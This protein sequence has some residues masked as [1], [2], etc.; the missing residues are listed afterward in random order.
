MNKA[1]RP[2]DNTDPD[3]SESDRVLGPKAWT[4]LIAIGLVLCVAILVVISVLTARPSVDPTVHAD[5]LAL[6]NSQQPDPSAPSRYPELIEALI[7]FDRLTVQIVQD[8]PSAEDD[9][10][11]RDGIVW[12]AILEEPDPEE[13]DL[14]LLAEKAEGV[15]QAFDILEEQG[16]FDRITEL[17]QSPNLATNYPTSLD[18]AG[19]VKPMIEWELPYLSSW[20]LYVDAIAARSRI[21]AEIGDPEAAA[22][23]LEL[24]SRLPGVLTR[25]ATFVERTVGLS[26]LAPI[27]REIEFICTRTEITPQVLTTL[28]AIHQQISDLGDPIVAIQGEKLF[29]RDMLYRTHTAG[30]RYI[31][32]S[33]EYFTSGTWPPEPIELTDR[34]KDVTGYVAASRDASLV[35]SEEIFRHYE[36]AMLEQDPVQRDRRIEDAHDAENS[37]SD[38]YAFLKAAGPSLEF[39][40]T[41]DFHHRA[42][43]TALGILLAMAE[44]RLDHGDWPTSLDQL[45][46]DYLDAIP[47]DP[48]TGDPF[49]YDHTPGESPSLERLGL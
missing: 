1:D 29:L 11:S 24:A 40:I 18:A 3:R 38:R 16:A 43:L 8:L 31:P 14:E 20:R 37:L 7:E 2:A 32:S 9:H 44:H 23:H 15:R 42:H 30:G 41:R 22:G 17:L 21:A 4:A 45:I 10:W 28:N 33:G 13:D 35:A 49:E 19:N 39:P 47:T 36:S 26:I 25:Y 46:P 27:G 6:A 48:R 5:M 12:S 34:I